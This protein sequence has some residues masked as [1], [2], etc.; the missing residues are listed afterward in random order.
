MVW[1]RRGAPKA[2]PKRPQSVPKVGAQ[3]LRPQSRPQ[4][5]PKV[6][7]QALWAQALWAQAL[8]AQALWAQALWAQALWAQ[9][10]RPYSRFT[11]SPALTG[12]E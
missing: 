11:R 5:V 1:F 3:C 8:W 7:A 12:N 9:A 2:P 10:L 4:S 6:G